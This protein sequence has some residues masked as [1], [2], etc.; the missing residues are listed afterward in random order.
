MMIHD[1]VKF[2]EAGGTPIGEAQNL[3]T[4]YTNIPTTG[5]FNSTCRRWNEKMEADNTWYNF[6]IQFSVSYRQHRQMYG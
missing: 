5:I 2:S 1:C 3:T 4:A 6:N